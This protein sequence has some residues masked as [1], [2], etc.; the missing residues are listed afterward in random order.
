MGDVHHC[1]RAP[2]SEMTYTVSSRTLNSTLPYHIMAYP[3]SRMERH[4]KLKIGKK[5]AHDT[6]DHLDIERS[7]VK[8]TRPLNTD[9]K[10]V[11]SLEREGRSTN[12]K[13]DVWMEYDN[14]HHRYER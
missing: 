5:E 3:K 14:P 12:F 8:V 13:L 4:S 7:K 2:V 11:V 10:S 1:S 9:R 6:G